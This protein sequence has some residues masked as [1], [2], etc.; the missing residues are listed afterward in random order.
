MRYRVSCEVRHKAGAVQDFSPKPP[1]LLTA[2]ELMTQ[3]TAVVIETERLGSIASMVFTVER[4]DDEMA[5][6][7]ADLERE[8]AEEE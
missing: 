4:H 5:D 7:D 8:A 3:L 1:R 6:F 2:A